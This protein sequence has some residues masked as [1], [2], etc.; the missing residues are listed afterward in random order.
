[1]CI[2]QKCRAKESPAGLCLVTL[3][4]FLKWGPWVDSALPAHLARGW[5]FWLDGPARPDGNKEVKRENSF[6]ICDT[7]ACLSLHPV[8]GPS[9]VQGYSSHNSQILNLA[10]CFHWPAQQTA[11]YSNDQ[12]SVSFPV[13]NH[14]L[15]TMCLLLG[16]HCSAVSEQL[17][18]PHGQI[19]GQQEQWLHRVQSQAGDLLI[20]NLVL[21]GTTGIQIILWLNLE[22]L[23]RQESVSAPWKREFFHKDGTTIRSVIFFDCYSSYTHMLV[24]HTHGSYSS[25]L[26]S[27]SFPHDESVTSESACGQS[28]MRQSQQET[29][30]GKEDCI[31]QSCLNKLLIF[32]EYQGTCL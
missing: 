19:C 9:S 31:W 15:L 1:M 20:W 24:Q 7:K 4:L 12:W 18:W 32:L 17:C 6:P 23:N 11:Q 5:T 2:P 22:L 16:T 8:S 26:S 27:F 13:Q 25:W 28:Y 29:K 14:H 21:L 30:W 10:T 3:L